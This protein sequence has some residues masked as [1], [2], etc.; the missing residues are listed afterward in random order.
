[1]QADVA[2]FALRGKKDEDGDEDQEWTAV[3]EAEK[4]E[5][6]SQP[7]ADAGGDL[8]RPPPAEAEGEERAQD[9]PAVHRKGGDEV[10][11]DEGDVGAGH[12]GEE[13]VGRVIEMRHRAGIEGGAEREVED[14]RYD[15]IDQRPGE[16]DDDLFRRLVGH[17][18]Q[19]CQPADRQEGDV[20]RRDAVAARRQRMAELV[21]ED[22][23][24]D[25]QDE[26]NRVD[27]RR[28]AALQVLAD[29]EPGEQEEERDMDADFRSGN[30]RNGDRPWHRFGSSCASEAITATRSAPVKVIWGRS[31]GGATTP[32]CR[33]RPI[34][35][36]RTR[37]F[38]WGPSP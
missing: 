25:R 11:Q 20:R 22:A 16:G 35:G 8:G 28:G 14:E 6:E 2:G 30:S 34:A 4:P 7:L 15:Q 18:R 33:R 1:M 12:P 26:R 29:T 32:A 5:N 36:G 3:E 31:G 13:A 19:P 27:G 23:G 21:E 17:A 10:E 24:E 37:R 38:R 9:T